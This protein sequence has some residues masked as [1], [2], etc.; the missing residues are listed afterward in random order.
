MWLRYEESD[1]ACP[2]FLRSN[3]CR[4]RPVHRAPVAHRARYWENAPWPPPSI[5]AMFRCTSSVMVSPPR[6]AASCALA[7]G[8]MSP[9][10]AS[11]HLPQECRACR[12]CSRTRSGATFATWGMSGSSGPAGRRWPPVLLQVRQAAP[13][14]GTAHHHLEVW[15]SQSD[16]WASGAPLE[17]GKRCSGPCGGNL[18]PDSNGDRCST[19]WALAPTTPCAHRDSVVLQLPVGSAHFP[20]SGLAPTFFFSE[21]MHQLLHLLQGQSGLP[22]LSIP[23]CSF[24]PIGDVRAIAPVQHPDVRPSKLRA[25]HWPSRRPAWPEQLQWA[26]SSV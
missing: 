16:A 14:M 18:T 24:F 6:H 26:C 15:L 5:T 13:S 4:R 10:P 21:L 8:R 25:A 7:P 2:W 1:K 3:S 17:D 20:G 9:R 11:L 12:A 19:C 23:A 22:S